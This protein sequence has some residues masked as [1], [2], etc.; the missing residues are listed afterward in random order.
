MRVGQSFV[1]DH[2]GAVRIDDL[3]REFHAFYLDRQRSGEPVEFGVPLLA[4]PAAASHDEIKRLIVRY[5]LDRASSS[6]AFWNT[7]AVKELSDLSSSS[8]TSCASTSCSMFRTA[9]TSNYAT[10]THE[11]HNR[12]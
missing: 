12:E 11:T 9:S 6:R 8:G 5:P 3:V 7:A 4:D 1:P 10:T 2:T